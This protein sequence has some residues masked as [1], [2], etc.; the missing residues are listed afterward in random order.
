[1]LLPINLPDKP[2]ILA[3]GSP[4]RAEI[5]KKIGLSFTI[6]PSVIDER[7]SVDCPPAEYTQDLAKR[8]AQAVAAQINDGIVIGAD[9]IV[10]LGK[11]IFGKPSSAAEA[12]EMLRRLAGKTHRV[13]TGFAI[14]DRPSNRAVTAGEMTEV[15]FRELDD[16]EI[17][18]Y[19]RSGEAMDKAGAYGIQDASAAFVERINGCFYNVVGFPLARFYLTLRSFY[20]S[21]GKGGL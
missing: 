10:V 4:R 16:A 5:L 21:R 15:A 12:G 18:A 3:S 7:Q 2:I 8:K 19:V 9:T 1:M 11:K 20:G 17:A 6:R 14:I 13:F